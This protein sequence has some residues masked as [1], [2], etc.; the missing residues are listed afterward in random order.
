[1]SDALVVAAAIVDDLESPR[2]LLAA[3]RS[4]PAALAGRWEFPG[5]KVEPDERP[6]D[7]LRREIREE[8]GVEITLGASVPGPV[9][10]AWPVHHGHSMRVWLA[11]I[12]DGAARP[13]LDHDGLRWLGPGSWFDVP[14][15]P[16]DMPIVAAI[17]RIGGLATGS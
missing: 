15:L 5:G 14:W 16:A 7:A 13:L 9:N 11:T 1:M 6:E 10:G 2:R 3:R 4:A 8:L 17:A 12:V